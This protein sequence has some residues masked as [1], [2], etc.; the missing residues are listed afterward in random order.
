MALSERS[1]KNLDGVHEDLVRVVKRADELATEAGLAFTITEGVR[2]LARQ[3]QLVASGAS[4]TMNSRHLTGDA[5]DFVPLVGN[6]PNWKWPAFWPLVEVFEKAAKE[7]GVA[8][9]CG[10]RWR[11]FPDGPHVQRPWPKKAK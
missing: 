6:E 8:I 2:T 5:F 11:R 3:R 9:E 10:A 1:L 4:S 7:L